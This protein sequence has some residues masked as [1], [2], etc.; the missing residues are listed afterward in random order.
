M[1]NVNT[2][3]PKW[4][5]SDRYRW[6]GERA[7][8]REFASPEELAAAGEGWAEN[9]AEAKAW[10]A[11]RA[12]VKVAPVAPPAPVPQAP[13]PISAPKPDVA[14]MNRFQMFAFLKERGIK[15][16]LPIANDELRKLVADELAHK[17]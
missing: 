4:W 6:D 15:A 12:S 2:P 5:P 17:G 7:V 9:Q 8:A 14:R 10:A 13:A 11:K 3:D 1:E 16:S